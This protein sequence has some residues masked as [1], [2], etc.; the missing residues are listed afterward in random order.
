MT[1]SNAAKAELLLIILC[2]SCGHQ[3]EP[4]RAEMALVTSGHPTER[5]TAAA[6]QLLSR[7]VVKQ[8]LCSWFVLKIEPWNVIRWYG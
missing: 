6:D 8:S 7:S 4:V 1:L 5:S 2:P 3:V